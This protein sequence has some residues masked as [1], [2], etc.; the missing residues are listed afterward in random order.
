M[1]LVM[2]TKHPKNLHQIQ[3]RCKE[4]Y[5]S[6]FHSFIGGAIDGTHVLVTVHV[7]KPMIC[8][9]KKDFKS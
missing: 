1:Y 9:L 4:I 3:P 5:G 6:N 8:S 7:Q 2:Y